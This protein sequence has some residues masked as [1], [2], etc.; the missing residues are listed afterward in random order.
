VVIQSPGDSSSVSAADDQDAAAAGIQTDVEVRTNLANND[1]VVLTVT[2]DRTGSVSLHE[3]TANSDGDVTFARVTLPSGPVTLEAEGSSDCGSGI[4]EVSVNVIGEALCD[5]TIV[6]GPIENDF[7]APIPVLNS[8]ND[9]DPALPNFQANLTVQTAEDFV[10]EV[11]VL[12]AGTGTEVSLG[13]IDANSDGVATAQTT[14][15]QGRQVVR[16]TCTKGSSNA[17]SAA[18]TVEVDTIVPTCTLTSPEEGVTITPDYD[19]DG[20]GANGIQMTWT[21]SVNAD[22]QDDILGESSSFFSDSME[23]PGTLIDSSGRAATEVP[24]GFSAPGD[25]DVSFQTQDHAGNA[26]LDGFTASVIMDGCSISIDSPATNAADPGTFVSVDSDGNPANGLQSDFTITVD[27]E[28][29]GQTVFVDCGVGASSAV[30]PANGVTTI[31]GVTLSADAVDENTELCTARVVNPDLFQTSVDRLVTFDTQAPG[32][33]LDFTFPTSLTCGDV[34]IRS[35]ANDATGSLA[36]G[37]QIEMRVIAPVADAQ[38]ISVSNAVCATPCI[39]P[40]P[41]FG[42]V[43]DIDITDGPND[44]RALTRDAVGNEASTFE[45]IV[46]LEDI[47]VEIVDP[48][49]TGLIGGNTQGAVVN[50]GG[51]LEITVCATVTQTDVVATLD[52]TTGGTTVTEPMSFVS[53]LNQFC[54]DTPVAFSEGV[55]QLTAT[56]IEIASVRQGSDS[57]DLTV[58]LTAP[59]LPAGFNFNASSPNHRDIETDWDAVGGI[60]GFVLKFTTGSDFTDFANEGTAVAGVGT[61]T[62]FTIG[63]LQAGVDYFVG[64]AITDAAGNLSEASTLGP[65][66]PSF[67][68]TGAQIADLATPSGF[69]RRFGQSIVSGNFNDDDFD[70]IAVAAPFNSVGANNAQGTVHIYFGSANG[71][72]A[73][74]D[75]T[76]N[77]SGPF[78]AFGWDMTRINWSTGAGDGLAISAP[79]ANRVF[80]FHGSTISSGAPLLTTAA[81]NV[82]ILPDA[83]ANWFTNCFLGWSLTTGELNSAS[84][85]EDL[86]IGAP[87]GDGGVGGAVI[88]Y[89]GAPVA[90][91]RTITLSETADGTAMSGLA[92]HIFENPVAAANGSSLG[93]KVEFLGDT[94]AGDGVGDIAISYFS[95]KTPVVQEDN[96][97]YVL[98]GRTATGA[99]GISFTPLRAT[100]LRVE[101]PS[102]E[103]STSFGMELASIDDQNSDG[104]RDLVISAH[105][106]SRGHVWIVNGSDTGT[107]VLNGPAD[108]LTNIVGTAANGSRFGASVANAR[109]QAGSDV[110]GDGLEDLVIAGGTPGSTTGVSLFLW[111]GGAIPVGDVLASSAASTIGAAPE[112]SNSVF[113]GAPNTL[114][115]IWAGDVNND[116][117]EDL[118]WT[119]WQAGADPEVE[120]RVEVLWDDPAN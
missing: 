83:A 57:L 96:A 46:R 88:I 98:R 12:D 47:G 22:G 105:E 119:D 36:D 40:A 13:K 56:A 7:F 71:I 120:G 70:D 20:D 64:V 53:G 104:F 94:R 116:G 103:A 74:P 117:L 14:L 33:N 90:G 112:F 113:G 77:G 35:A 19:E 58:D 11:F 41:P 80:I 66:T 10:V 3:S 24:S 95:D 21:G 34:V 84:S 50:G 65:F 99:S 111:F 82:T 87:S 38:D 31:T 91:N 68:P 115:L 107:V 101:N 28:C 51:D 60:D 18:N 54:T 102:T 17:A 69:A 67:D 5:L 97:V 110:N 75:V 59:T 29:A 79:F 49:G 63:N 39:T 85:V 43:I 6:E 9:S 44:I 109:Q 52:V 1:K 48:V 45:C 118:A 42:G 86:V 114:Q 25:F 100:D 62:S 32:G 61:A 26:C 23:F 93:Y 16:A 8:S 89:G 2:D 37:F 76:I 4:D 73:T 106:Q 108:Y 81:A 72:G 78:T 92:A 15:G 27:T 30:A 55:H